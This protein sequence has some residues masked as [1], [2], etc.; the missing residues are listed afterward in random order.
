M[1][2]F[3]IGAGELWAV[4]DT[5]SVQ[6]CQGT[7]LGTAYAGNGDG[8]NNPLATDEVMH[9]PLPVGLYTIGTPINKPMSVGVYALPLTP[10]PSNCMFGR[11]QFY[12]HGDNAQANHTAS[13]GCIVAERTIREI[14][15]QHQ[16]L[17]VVM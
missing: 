3:K 15:A 17:Q 12:I 10:N 8:I 5:S 9:G 4:D 2:V 7:L 16:T 14:C 11:S 6:T 13:D 1:I